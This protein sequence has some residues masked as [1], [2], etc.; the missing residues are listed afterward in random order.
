MCC[1]KFC[2]YIRYATTVFM[3]LILDGLPLSLSV[4]VCHTSA[5]TILSF[6]AL[7]LLVGHVT[8]YVLGR[9][10]NITY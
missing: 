4:V 3:G 6:V 7:T 9:T 8:Y 2:I 1:A 10:L 5:L